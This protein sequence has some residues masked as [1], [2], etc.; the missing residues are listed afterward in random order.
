MDCQPRNLQGIMVSKKDKGRPLAWLVALSGALVVFLSGAYLVYGKVATQNLDGLVYS[1]Q[2]SGQ[3]LGE[4]LGPTTLEDLQGPASF[5]LAEVGGLAGPTPSTLGLYPGPLMPF[6]SWVEPWL[7]S[8]PPT[9]DSE[10]VRGFLPAPKELLSGVG[11]L[12]AATRIWIP[13]IEVDATVKGLAI[14]ELENSREYETP[15]QVVGHIPTTGNPGE[16][17]RGWYFGHL[18]T[19]LRNEGS[20]F[21]DLPR[22]PGLLRQGERVLIVLESSTGNYLYEVYATNVV[23]KT[24][25]RVTDSG[26]SEITLVT[27]IPAL[28]YDYRLVVTARLVGVRPPV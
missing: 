7:A 24:E 13:S 6:N 28:V 20:V 1:Q 10:F 4:A 15:D 22:I 5:N 27:C 19:P 16:A 21:R 9:D 3:S 17:G 25:L 14:R 11:M 8:A 26:E 23:Y 18:E 2:P 12:P